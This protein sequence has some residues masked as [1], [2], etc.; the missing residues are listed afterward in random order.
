M[1]AGHRLLGGVGRAMSLLAGL[2]LLWAAGC[3]AEPFGMARVHGK[4]TYEDGTPIKAFRIR[5]IFNPQVKA[6]DAETF[7]RPGEATVNAEDGTF[8]TVTTHKYGDGL[9]VGKHKVQVISLDER[10]NTTNAVPA[11]YRDAATTP[12]EV[13]V[14]SGMGPI[15]LKIKKQP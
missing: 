14:R 12:L 11:V 5:V 15:E 2:A 9:V 6:I 4:V 1:N 3:G 7:P 13:D 8:D 10:E